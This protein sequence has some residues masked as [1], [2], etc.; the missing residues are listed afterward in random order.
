MG[1]EARIIHEGFVLKQSRH[2]GE[3]RRR[4]AV[5]TTSSF[6]TFENKEESHG[7]LPTEVVSLRNLKRIGTDSPCSV[8]LE[9]GE[10]DFPLRFESKACKDT[11]MN[12][13]GPI[14]AVGTAKDSKLELLKILK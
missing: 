9:T 3:W 1:S 14:I 10:G 2:L 13:L 8:L 4:W 5:L 7:G 12:L 6:S 11:W